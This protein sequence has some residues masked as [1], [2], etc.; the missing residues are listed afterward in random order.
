MGKKIIINIFFLSLICFTGYSQTAEMYYESGK[1]KKDNKDYEAAIIDLTKSIELNPSYSSAYRTR[2]L[3]KSKLKDYE[4]AIE[5]YD[6]AI[7]L[8]SNSLIYLLRAMAKYKLHDN[9]GAKEDIYQAKNAII[10]FLICLALLA[11]LL[12]RLVLKIA[13]KFKVENNKEII[14]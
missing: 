6:K 14:L 9:I 1:Q 11:Y 4:G 7:E 8:N 3:V 10:I 5:D 13:R 2:G 12:Y